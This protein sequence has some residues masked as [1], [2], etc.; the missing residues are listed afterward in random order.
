[1]TVSLWG[2]GAWEAP[3]KD[4]EG[5]ESQRPTVKSPRARRVA[6]RD[7]SMWPCIHLSPEKKTRMS[8]LARRL[9]ADWATDDTVLW[10]LLG[11]YER[12]CCWWNRNVSIRLCTHRN[13]QM[14]NTSCSR[15]ADVRRAVG[16]WHGMAWHG[17]GISTTRR[18]PTSPAS[19]STV[20]T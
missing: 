2:C 1:M 18:A 4:D 7:C 19:S 14:Q 15:T 20:A 12:T 5:S 10:E 9:E 6:S 17:N 11:H 8:Y 13:V 3:S 16:S